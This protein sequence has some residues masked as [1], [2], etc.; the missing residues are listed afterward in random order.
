MAR[1][2]PV[3]EWTHFFLA[4]VLEKKEKEKA[5]EEREKKRRKTEEKNG[6]GKS[7]LIMATNG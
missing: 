5:E 2:A 6:N 7:L 3:F 1:Y 4:N